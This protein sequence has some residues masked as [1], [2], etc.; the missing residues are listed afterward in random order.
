[1]HTLKIYTFNLYTLQIAIFTVEKVCPKDFSK[2]VSLENC[3]IEQF[4]LPETLNRNLYFV[5]IKL[6]VDFISEAFDIV[7]RNFL[8]V[9]FLTVISCTVYSRDDFL[10]N[11]I[12]NRNREIQLCMQPKGR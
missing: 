9:M 4:P 3:L 7:L 5:R 1:M 6:L 8:L 2:S 10:K 12:G 11:L